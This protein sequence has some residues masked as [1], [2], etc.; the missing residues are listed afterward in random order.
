MV[1][2]HYRGLIAS[3][4][5]IGIMMKHMNGETLKTMAPLA[6]AVAMVA[7]MRFL[8]ANAWLAGAVFATVL[9]L[10]LPFVRPIGDGHFLIAAFGI[11][12]AGVAWNL[13]WSRGD[14]AGVVATHRVMAFGSLAALLWWHLSG[15]M[16][17]GNGWIELI[18]MPLLALFSLHPM[19]H[20]LF[21]ARRQDE[22][23][24]F[25]PQAFVA[26]LLI[27]MVMLPLLLRAPSMMHATVGAMALSVLAMVPRRA[28]T[29][30][31]GIYS[32]LGAA[33]L[34]TLASYAAPSL[35]GDLRP[36]LISANWPGVVLS[37]I[38]IVAVFDK[39]LKRLGRK[40]EEHLGALL[41]IPAVLAYLVITHNEGGHWQSLM[42][43]AFAGITGLIYLAL[44]KLDLVPPR[45][46]I[47][48]STV[49]SLLGAGISAGAALLMD[50]P[51]NIV[52][53]LLISVVG[54]GSW[55]W[56]AMFD[57]RREKHALLPL[58]VVALSMGIMAFFIRFDFQSSTLLQAALY[59]AGAFVITRLLSR[60]HEQV[61]VAVLG[62]ALCAVSS[63]YFMAKP[64]IGG[65]W[66]GLGMMAMA[67]WMS[68][69]FRAEA[70]RPLGLAVLYAGI[71]LGV[72]SL[73]A[74]LPAVITTASWGV[75][76]MALL[77]GGFVLREAAWRHAAI[78]IFA[79]SILRLL[80]IDMAESNM[81][82][83][84]LASIGVGAL[85]VAAAYL[86]AFLSKNLLREPG[87]KEATD[88]ARI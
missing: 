87:A 29:W 56:L 27:G 88:K 13:L 74:G 46:Q 33:L 71:L 20:G 34:S 35:L 37:T 12:A 47:S 63:V 85:M 9:G 72:V 16:S 5:F 43:L 2:G 15:L 53:A 45:R 30:R 62:A 75:L 83:R 58:F 50:C 4:A 55:A 73:A 14:S 52:P 68:R 6:L 31:F 78:G 11:L 28:T 36:H 3:A 51:T 32:A 41:A 40:P 1:A 22:T 8:R 54:L 84:I 23:H 86:Y 7:G 17:E 38:A 76:A 82:A 69:S 48:A 18:V 57:L 19:L 59:I 44:G 70:L 10:L 26:T 80:V 49:T 61:C 81:N 25:T 77:V 66:I 79:L 65:A 21:A 24:E 64:S 42:L 67:I 60:E 39:V